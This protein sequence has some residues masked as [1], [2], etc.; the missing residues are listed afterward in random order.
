MPSTQ[1][2]FV[3]IRSLNRPSLAP[4]TFGLIL[5]GLLACGWGYSQ[6]PLPS[7]SPAPTPITKTGNI[8]VDNPSTV[9]RIAKWV[10]SSSNGTGTIGNSVITESSIGT[11]GIGTNPFSDFKLAVD[12]GSIGGLY[13]TSTGPSPGVLGRNETGHGVRGESVSGLGLHGRSITGNGVFG[14]SD[15]GY[16]VQGV[17]STGFAGFFQGRVNVTG[18][19]SI[20]NLLMNAGGTLQF[21]DGTIQSTAF[22]GQINQSQV[23]NLIPTLASKA[24]DSGVVHLSGTETITGAKTFSGFQLFSGNLGI[25]MHG[26]TTDTLLNVGGNTGVVAGTFI[27]NHNTSVNDALY[28]VHTGRGNAFH[29]LNT[30]VIGR[31]GFFENSHTNSTS[32]VLETLGQGPG[33]ALK[34]SNTGTGPAAV[35]TSGNVGIGTAAPQARLHVSNAGGTAGQFDGNVTIDGNLTLNGSSNISPNVNH[36]STLTGNGS[37]ASPLSVIGAPNGVVTTGSYANPSW[38]TSLAGR[39]IDGQI[40]VRA[41]TI[42][43]VV[44]GLNDGS[45]IGVF[46]FST[47]G[48]G[49]HGHTNSNVMSG[50]YGRNPVGTAGLFEGVTGVYGKAD[51]NNNPFNM[52]SYGV[53]GESTTGVGVSGSGGIGVRGDSNS[54]SGYGVMG[55]NTA[56]GD[57]GFFDGKVTINGN[58][59]AT[60]VNAD[61]L[62]NIGTINTASNPVDWSALKNVPSS[63]ASGQ[64]VNSVNGVV[65]NVSLVAGNNVSI[66]PTGNTIT[67]ASTLSGSSFV[68]KTGDTMTGTLNLPS[69]GLVAGG[70][71]LV[72]SGGNVGIGTTNPAFKLDVAGSMRTNS[73][74]LPTGTI[75]SSAGS[76]RL[77]GT[78]TQ[79]GTT[80]GFLDLGPGNFYYPGGAVTLGAG[81]TAPFYDSAQGSYIK[82]FGNDYSSGGDILIASGH[83]YG[84]VDGQGTGGTITLATSTAYGGNYPPPGPIVF[85]IGPTERF[86]V[87]SNGN[88]GI[89]TNT[90]GSP[91]EVRGAG[92]GPTFKAVNANNSLAGQFDGNVTINGNLTVSGT[93]SGFTIADG[94]VTTGKL[95]D[96]AV[97]GQKIAAGQVVKS[98]NSL[99]DSVTLVAGD[100]VT[101]TPSGNSLTIAATGAGAVPGPL[102]LVDSTNAEVGLAFPAFQTFSND[103]LIVTV[104]RFRPENNRWLALDASSEGFSEGFHT[105]FYMNGNCVGTPYLSSHPTALAVNAKVVGG[106]FYIPN[107]DGQQ[108]VPVSQKD[109]FGNC[110][111]FGSS[112]TLFLATFEIV[113]IS[114]LGLTPPFKLAR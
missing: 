21:P 37:S 49:V 2:R 16:G 68:A 38:I 80:G 108:L 34:S 22:T 26:P 61:N 8:L 101:I 15:S 7:P 86:R 5:I 88:V 39:K 112:Q 73:I 30:Q 40:S 9:G 20:G 96:S 27:N 63:I 74:D 12:G 64:V 50:V 104:Y 46:G 62:S 32:P 66:T 47:G 97:T 90:P 75:N 82:L 95:A 11:I 81:A 29:A 44:T 57:A 107:A 76:L 78:T 59:N 54:S 111:P 105:I 102:R 55:T 25:G 106:N 67:I 19:L 42:E 83:S 98:L 60:S 69:N 18:L 70:N 94:A 71:Q 114:D 91:L 72:L 13:G 48:N 93:S 99:T 110:S 17:S 85:K 92:A 84:S 33:P 109:S 103:L 77:Q 6:T 14:A 3:N 35:F 24:N 89:G 113:P 52:P 53:R 45:G 56:G 65:N 31:A 79:Q 36:D 10:N 51:P 41:T 58:L 23:I 43:A 87:N 1:T 28:A 4:R 100:N